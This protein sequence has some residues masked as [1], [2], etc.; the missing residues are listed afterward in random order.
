[1]RSPFGAT[2]MISAPALPLN[3]SLSTPASPSTRSLPSPGIPLDGVVAGAAEL[4]IVAL[5][6]VDEVVALAARERVGAVAAEDGV[7]A[8][9]AVDRRDDERGEVARGG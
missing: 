8:V 3:R 5:L 4:L 6:T 2:A 9:A 1:M 7:V